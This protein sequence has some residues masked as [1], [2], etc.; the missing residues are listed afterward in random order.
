M[1]NTTET[2]IQ[3][4]NVQ[5][6]QKV[7]Y[8]M[9]E[10]LVY[11]IEDKKKEIKKMMDKIQDQMSKTKRGKFA[12][13]LWYIDKGEKTEDEKKQWLIENCNAKYCVF[14]P[15]TYIVKPK[16]ISDLL[17]QIK[18][19]ET[20]TMKLKDMGVSLTGKKYKPDENGK[21]TEN[22]DKTN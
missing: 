11:G 16:Y 4:E 21:E 17:I 13:I 22:N 14:A 1:I 12:R 3:N 8:T 9:L 15:T 5:Q 7:P 18:K 10:V 20:T 2:P 6:N 19:F